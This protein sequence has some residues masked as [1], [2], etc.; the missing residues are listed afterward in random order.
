MGEREACGGHPSP[1]QGGFA[2]CSPD[3]GVDVRF[4]KKECSRNKGALADSFYEIVY[5]NNSVLD[6][7]MLYSDSIVYNNLRG[8]C[9]VSIKDVAEAAGVSTATVSRVLS[10]G[11]HVPPAFR[12]RRI[13]PA[14]RFA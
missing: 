8:V 11:P 6:G 4:R 9:M 13:A 3:V 10:N 2:P 7:N 12:G 14:E 1:R 5:K